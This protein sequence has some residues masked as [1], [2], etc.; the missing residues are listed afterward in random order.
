M[1]Q[2]A[3]TS[4]AFDPRLRFDIPNAVNLLGYSRAKLYQ[5]IKSGSIRIIR[6]GRRVFIPGSE[7]ARK[8]SLDDNGA[9]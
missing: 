7:I 1:T 2:T 4:P 8:S 6:D 5:E 3:R 9:A